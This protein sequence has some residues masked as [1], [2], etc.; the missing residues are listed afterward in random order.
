[1]SPKK[2]LVLV[3]GPT[4]AAFVD[5]I[6]G[7]HLSL[8]G[9]FLRARRLDG[10]SRYALLRGELVRL[11]KDN[12]AVVVTTMLDFYRFPADFSGTLGSNDPGEGRVVSLEAAIAADLGQKTRFL[13]YLSR[14]EFEALVLA[15]GPALLSVLPGY[16]SNVS[17]LLTSVEAF[18]TPED[19]DDGPRTHPSMRL[20]LLVPAFKKRVDGLLAIQRAGLPALRARCPHF[21]SWVTRLEAI[22][23][24]P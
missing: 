4:E 17:Q 24:A 9:L 2:G 14:H 7:P 12:S 22:A 8:S 13:P 20:E 16:E 15:T 19:I 10:V 1:L 23:A 5:Q 18:K 11:M 6:L 21:D 3:E